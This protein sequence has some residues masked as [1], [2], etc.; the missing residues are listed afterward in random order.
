MGQQSV[1]NN[2]S[3]QSRV[4]NS[5]TQGQFGNEGVTGSDYSDDYYY[6]YYN[7]PS[8]VAIA[9]TTF[10]SNGEPLV[11]SVLGPWQTK[12]QIPGYR[13]IDPPSSLPIAQPQSSMLPTATP[14][15]TPSL[16]SPVVPP[17]ASQLHGSQ[18]FYSPVVPT[19]PSFNFSIFTP[20]KTVV[21]LTSAPT[22]SPTSEPTKAPAQTEI[23]E[24]D[25]IAYEAVGKADLSA[26][27]KNFFEQT[28]RLL[29]PYLA[30]HVGFV[31][32]NYKLTITFV[33]DT[34]GSQREVQGDL[35]FYLNIFEIKLRLELYGIP[36]QL[37]PFDKEKMQDLVAKFLTGDNLV[38]LINWMNTKDI[39]IKMIR[40][41]DPNNPSPIPTE[42]QHDEGNSGGVSNPILLASLLCFSLVLLSV[43]AVFY[44]KRRTTRLHG[45]GKMLESPM[46]SVYSNGSEDGSVA[47]GARATTSPKIR[48]EH[49]EKD[50][51][52]AY[53]D[54]FLDPSTEQLLPTPYRLQNSAS[55][56]N[57]ERVTEETTPEDDERNL[58]FHDALHEEDGRATLESLDGQGSLNRLSQTYPEFDMFVNV[59]PAGTEALPNQGRSGNNDF[60]HEDNR[61][62]YQEVN[63]STP[64]GLP[65][66]ESFG[67]DSENDGEKEMPS[68]L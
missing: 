36:P 12:P 40:L 56:N 47:V 67:M 60:H 35:N 42:G 46:N 11:T 45:S 33:E 14:V 65:D 39:P 5:W 54:H 64:V 58:Y 66:H 15:P 44:V 25:P 10:N 41:Y 8:N 23:I 37:K 68:L 1:V 34:D 38:E 50:L 53:E 27:E 52:H 7:R 28:E 29:T 22:V 18:P 61:I 9:K 20:P 17:S 13:P 62:R 16:T 59:A 24:T 26:I 2:S 49:Q 55:Q 19:V 63:D 21:Q 32:R 57:T 4:R 6:Y 48:T 51:E 31:L 43:A 30:K 3:G